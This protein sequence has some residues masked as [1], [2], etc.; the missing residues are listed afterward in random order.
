[1]NNVNVLQLYANMQPNWYFKFFLF[2]LD[3]ENIIY[4]EVTDS[5]LVPDTV[6]LH[7]IRSI[8]Y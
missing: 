5:Y 8:H 7:C 3:T 1:M 2:N 4:A 6:L